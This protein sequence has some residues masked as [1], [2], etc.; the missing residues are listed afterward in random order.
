MLFFIANAK[1]G[2]KLCIATTLLRSSPERK[3]LQIGCFLP[4][5]RAVSSDTAFFLRCNK[6]SLDFGVIRILGLYPR[7]RP[8]C[9]VKSLGS[10]SGQT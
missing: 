9:A 3:L 10:S 1:E 6:N 5:T 8:V 4:I 7:H 2:F